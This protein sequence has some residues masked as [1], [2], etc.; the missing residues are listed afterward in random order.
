MPVVRPLKK[1]KSCQLH[2]RYFSRTSKHS[3]HSHHQFVHA[4]AIAALLLEDL[5]QSL[6]SHFRNSD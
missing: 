5:F 6:D 3:I 2:Q 1:N 4:A